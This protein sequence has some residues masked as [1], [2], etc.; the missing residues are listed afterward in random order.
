MTGLLVLGYAGFFAFGAYFFALGQQNFFLFSMV[1][2]A[3]LAFPL[4]GLVGYLLGLPLSSLRG[5]YL[6][7]VTLGFAEAFSRND[8]ES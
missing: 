4:G 7:I 6:A 1:A 3:P 2:A 5:D 8:T